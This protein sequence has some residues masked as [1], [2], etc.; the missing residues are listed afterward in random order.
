MIYAETSQ[1]LRY[2]LQMVGAVTINQLIVFFRDE[3]SPLEIKYYA[4]NLVKRGDADYDE[5]TGTLVWHKYEKFSPSIVRSKVEAFWVVAYFGSKAVKDVDSLKFPLQ[6]EMI[7]CAEGDEDTD[8][9]GLEVYDIAVCKTTTD[10]TIAARALQSHRIEGVP[11]E[12]VHL[13]IV[14]DAEIGKKMVERY[15]FDCYILLKKSR[16]TTNEIDV[17]IPEFSE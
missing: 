1:N 12:V 3:A 16:D 5:R 15:G 6:I 11:D 4:S 7:L 9:P 14:Q 8:E 13:V 17:F 10:G 2:L